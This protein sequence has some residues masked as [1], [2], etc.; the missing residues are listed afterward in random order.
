M[1][2]EIP[3]CIK[4]A[5]AIFPPH[6]EAECGHELSQAVDSDLQVYRRTT[7]YARSVLGKCG[8]EA[9]LFKQKELAA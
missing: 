9:K 6:S 7:Q 5:H 8:P 1:N 2:T 3:K 4:C